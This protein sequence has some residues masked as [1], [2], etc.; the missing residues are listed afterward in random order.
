MKIDWS[1][2]SSTTGPQFSTADFTVEKLLAAV[3]EAE[4]IRESM[5]AEDCVVLTDNDLAELRK[6]LP[7]SPVPYPELTNIY[8]LEIFT[9]PTFFECYTL[10]R[11]L[12]KQGRRPL[13]VTPNFGSQ[14]FEIQTPEKFIPETFRQRILGI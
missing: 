4:K 1:A 14:T 5:P 10:A 9:R 11:E 3:D 7:E 6:E 12:K 2:L 8:G 13:L